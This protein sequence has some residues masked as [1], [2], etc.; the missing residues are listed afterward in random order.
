MEGVRV[1]SIPVSS[2]SLVPSLSL[3]LR[4]WDVG[5]GASLL[6]LTGRTNTVF[7]VVQLAD[8]RIG[9]GS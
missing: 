4:V 3:V 8:G 7:C 9:S 5:T 2:P 6:E 1:I